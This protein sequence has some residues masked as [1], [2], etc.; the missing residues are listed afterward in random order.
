MIEENSHNIGQNILY[1][2]SSMSV[3]MYLS[4]MEPS[5]F[6]LLGFSQIKRQT[7]AACVDGE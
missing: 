4:Y 7:N 6:N 2:Q 3:C 5:H 1:L